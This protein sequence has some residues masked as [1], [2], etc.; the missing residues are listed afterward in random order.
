M[1]TLSY[2][3]SLKHFNVRQ[4]PGTKAIWISIVWT[5]VAIVIP[6]LI[7]D[8]FQWWNL[9]Y[10]ILFFALTIPGDLR[11]CKLDNPKMK[12]IP[13]LIG[14]Q[15]AELLFYLLNAV[16]L[17]LYFFI[18]GRSLIEIVTSFLFVLII[19]RIHSHFRYELMDGLLFVLGI[20]YLIF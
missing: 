14:N 4:I 18:H 20:S 7:Y 10:L 5:C 15:N 3:L 19:F 17:S 2:I 11:D 13:Q 8:S 9:N 16:F 12:T 1:I 6:K